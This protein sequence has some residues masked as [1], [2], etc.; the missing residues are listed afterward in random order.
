MERWAPVNS[1]SGLRT[2]AEPKELGR[3]A[4]QLGS[5]EFRNNKDS[6]HIAALSV[7]TGLGHSDAKVWTNHIHSFLESMQTYAPL[8]K[9]DLSHC[10]LSNHTISGDLKNCIEKN[11]TLT[12]LDLSNNAFNDDGMRELARAIAATDNNNLHSLNLA[13]NDFTHES[14][15]EWSTTL[16]SK[17]KLIKQLRLAFTNIGA[18]GVKALGPGLIA[19]KELELLDLEG[20][21]MGDEGAIELAEVMG[22]ARAFNKLNELNICDNRIG[23]VGIEKICGKLANFRPDFTTINLNKNQFGDPGLGFVTEVMKTDKQLKKLKMNQCG[24][25]IRGFTSFCEAL[26]VRYNNEIDEFPELTDLEIG[27]NGLGNNLTILFDVLKNKNCTIEFVNYEGNDLNDHGAHL[28]AVFLKDKK[29]TDRNS[30][31]GN[32]MIGNTMMDKITQENQDDDDRE[33]YTNHENLQNLE[34]MRR[35]NFNK[36][37][38]KSNAITATGAEELAEVLEENKTITMFDL[39]KNKIGVK[40]ALY[41]KKQFQKRQHSPHNHQF[42]FKILSGDVTAAGIN[43]LAIGMRQSWDKMRHNM[44]LNA[45]DDKKRRFNSQTNRPIYEFKEWDTKGD[46]VKIFLQGENDDIVAGNVNDKLADQKMDE[47]FPIWDTVYTTSALVT[48]ARGNYIWN[49]W[50]WTLVKLGYGCIVANS[51]YRVGY[52]LRYHIRDKDG[53]SPSLL[54]NL[55][56]DRLSYFWDQVM[57]QTCVESEGMTMFEFCLKYS[58]KPVIDVVRQFINVFPV[59]NKFDVFL[60]HAPAEVGPT[61][62]DLCVECHDPL[63]RRYASAKDLICNRFV[64]TEDIYKSRFTRIR[65]VEDL[66]QTEELDDDD[67]FYYCRTFADSDKQ[68]TEGLQV[69]EWEAHQSFRH[70]KCGYN[71]EYI[72]TTYLTSFDVEDIIL[73]NTNADLSSITHLS[74]IASRTDT[75]HFVLTADKMAPTFSRP[76]KMTLRDCLDNQSLAGTDFIKRVQNIGFMIGFALR[77]FNDRQPWVKRMKEEQKW[78]QLYSFE[79]DGTPECKAHMARIEANRVHGNI[80]P[81]N[82]VLRDL[83]EMPDLVEGYDKIPEKWI[84]TDFSRSVQHGKPYNA[85][86][87]SAYAAPELARRMYSTDINVLTKLDANEKIDVWSFGCVLFEMLSGTSLFKMETRDDTLL[88]DEERA[89]LANWL[90]LDEERLIFLSRWVEDDD[91]KEMVQAGKELVQWCLQGRPGNRPTFK[92]ILEHPFLQHVNPGYDKT[93]KIYDEAIKEMSKELENWNID[94]RKLLYSSKF[95]NAEFLASQP[96]VHVVNS[97]FDE[98]GVVL[99]SLEQQLMTVGCNITT[100]EINDKVDDDELKSRVNSARIIV[101]LLT[102]DCF[103]KAGVVRQLLHAEDFKRKDERPNSKIL[104]LNVNKALNM[105]ANAWDPA[106]FRDSWTT[107]DDFQYLC[108]TLAIQ[109]PSFKKISVTTEFHDDLFDSWMTFLKTQAHALFLSYLVETI[110]YYPEDYLAEASKAWMMISGDLMP[111]KLLKRYSNA[112]LDDNNYHD[113]KDTLAQKLTRKDKSV[114]F[115]S[116]RKELPGKPRVYVLTGKGS[117]YDTKNAVAEIAKVLES[118]ATEE[119][120]ADLEED[121]RIIINKVKTSFTIKKDSHVKFSQRGTRYAKLKDTIKNV[122]RKPGA[123]VVVAV[124]EPGF[125]EKYGRFLSDAIEKVPEDIIIVGVNHRWNP[126]GSKEMKEMKSYCS[127]RLQKVFADHSDHLLRYFRKKDTWQHKAMLD[128]VVDRVV[129]RLH[130]KQS[131]IDNF[132]EIKA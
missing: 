90:A 132:R 87:N 50:V 126:K 86:E 120:Q 99:R 48:D 51:L 78:Q 104:F 2:V 7:K 27:K 116:G 39:R 25:S 61:L 67:R 14:M 111:P 4:Q 103:T 69:N 21:N 68:R 28:W 54:R 35:K 100:D 117:L 113:P 122:D 60:N 34:L 83:S 47:I 20:V 5:S 81:R 102:R 38:L 129:Y 108:K 121:Q 118:P 64:S 56:A 125:F 53:N 62:R 37:S 30:R 36:L 80:K 65:R 19:A 33:K 24:Y 13:Y 96:H 105:K 91:N 74:A 71:G 76:F 79:D 57:Y 8:V 123:L 12:A 77:Q 49:K 93:I 11:V 59:R 66:F 88:D 6:Q 70:Y 42:T 98:A 109:N 10:Q 128:E 31:D 101:C 114:Y 18:E 92:Q 95:E 55:V 110:P 130:H 106:S 75:Y 22:D 29:N 84:L 40:G 73:C 94:G 115:V 82:I 41:F 46:E 63:V 112:E 32:Q 1:L 127:E 119:K 107:S 26:L 43:H 9:L 89:E 85:P 97:N 58:A 124:L 52:I 17:P 3:L 15:D 72:D 16:Q 45:I 44:T 131:M 23:R